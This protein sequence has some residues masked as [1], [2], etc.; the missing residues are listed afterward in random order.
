MDAVEYILSKNR[1]DYQRDNFDSFLSKVK[2]SFDV[3]AIH[4]AGTNGKGSV[5]HFL[6]DIYTKNGYKVGLFTSPDEIQEMIKI[7]DMCCDFAYIESVVN[8]YK[9][10]FEKYDLST[11]EIETFIALKWFQ[12][13]K[14]DLAIVECGMGGEYDATNIFTPVLSIITSVSLEHTEFLGVSLSEV[15]QHKSGI[16]KKDIPVLIGDVDG[17]ALNVIVS[18]AKRENSRIVMV[19][20][21]HNYKLDKGSVFDYRPYYG[22]KIQSEA[23]YR[24]YNACMAIEATNI[25]EDKFPVKED[26]LKE[27]L[28]FSK[29][30]CR[31]EI[32]DYKPIIVLDGAH[33]PDG[34]NKLRIEFDRCYPGR[35]V[36]VVFASFKDK[37]ISLMLPEI[38]LIGDIHLTTFNNGRA[39]K[40]SD[41]FLYLEDY[42]YCE[43]YQSLIDRFINENPDDILLITGSLSFAYTVR[44]YLKQRGIIND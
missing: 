1:G 7:G 33:N 17:D 27:G 39:R 4:I 13:S 19:D 41:Y 5:A 44:K 11:F 10:L 26:L 35:P 15:A 40:D 43:D 25:L 36:H 42:E 31:F 38:G 37:N 24:V 12:D 8:E 3:P 14:A 30:K 9:K 29:L 6:C 22:L 23:T 16:I 2:F 21:Y 32:I 28:M 18:K 20:K 34:I